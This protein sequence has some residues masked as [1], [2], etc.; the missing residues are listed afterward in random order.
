MEQLV[1]N[2]IDWAKE[3]NLLNY[4]NAEKQY[5]KFL[6][7]VGETAKA[8]L[9][10]DQ[11]GIVDGFGDI[12]VTI[13]ILFEQLKGHHDGELFLGFDK[14]GLQKESRFYWFMEEIADY[15][16]SN[17]SL[18]YL[19]DVSNYYGYTLEHCLSVAWNE[20]KN[21]TGKTENGVFIKD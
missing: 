13:I 20:I 18:V 2:V 12:A 21:R 16:V 6:E 7:E 17:Q 14:E 8:I 11:N 19:N 3:R 9:K 1:K 5:H 15:S 10:N 4:S